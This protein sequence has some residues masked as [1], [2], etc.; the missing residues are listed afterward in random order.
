MDIKINLL[1]QYKL[2]VNGKVFKCSNSMY[3]LVRLVE[4]YNFKVWHITNNLQ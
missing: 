1:I 3:D 4:K 2:V